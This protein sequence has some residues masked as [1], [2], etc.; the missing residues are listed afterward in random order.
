LSPEIIWHIVLTE[1]ALVINK[2]PDKYIYLFTDSDKQKQIVVTTDDPELIDLELIIENLKSLIPSD[3]SMFFPTIGADKRANFALNAAFADAM[4]V[5]YSYAIY[6]C[7]LPAVNVLGDYTHWGN[8]LFALGKL[9][10]TFPDLV[11]YFLRVATQVGKIYQSILD[12]KTDVQF[13]KDIFRLEKCGSGH[14]VE[15]KG[16]ITDFF[17]EKPKLGYMQNFSSCVSH[18]PYKN[19]TTNKEFEIK[20]GLFTSQ[21][22]EYKGTNLPEFL[23]PHFGFV[24]FE[25]VKSNDKIRLPQ[26][27]IDKLSRFPESGMGYQYVDIT[28]KS[29]KVLEKIIVT[30]SSFIA[31]N[32]VNLAEE[33]I[34]DVKF[35]HKK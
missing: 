27:L 10:A 26:H 23:L 19:L 8:M 33:D 32:E 3:T 5:Y 14:Q 7:G 4:K 20:S 17:V 18:V 22:I 30:N 25:N 29:G 31:K 9:T 28:L 16:W 2:E 13:F 6:R 12:E 1:I 24:I 15:I 35:V 11:D 34:E 21:R